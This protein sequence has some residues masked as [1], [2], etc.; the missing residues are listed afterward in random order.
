MTPDWDCLEEGDRIHEQFQSSITQEPPRTEAEPQQTDAEPEPM[1]AEEQRAVRQFHLED[2]VT[3]A[4]QTLAQVTDTLKAAR[5]ALRAFGKSGGVAVA[6]KPV[7][8]DSNLGRIVQSL[9]DRE[10]SSTLTPMSLRDFYLGS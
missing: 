1:S 3:R 9:A 5:A 10:L 8:G 7:K 6:L 4:E 2:A